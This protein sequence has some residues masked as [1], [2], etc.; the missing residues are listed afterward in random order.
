MRLIKTVL[1]ILV[2]LLGLNLAIEGQVVPTGSVEVSVGTDKL[3]IVSGNQYLQYDPQPCTLQ[4]DIEIGVLIMNHLSITGEV[5][6]ISD[7][8]IN[9]TIWLDPYQAEYLINASVQVWDLEVGMK[10]GCYHPIV[11]PYHS[12]PEYY[13]GYTRMY[14][15]WKW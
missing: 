9:S 15:K 2:V 14:G 1:I 7:G 10:H 4:I 11:N 8:T 3:M 13:G 5:R 6:T 12:F